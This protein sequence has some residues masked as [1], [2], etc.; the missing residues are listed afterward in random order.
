MPLFTSATLPEVA[1]KL[2]VLD[3]FGA[4]RSRLPPAPCASWIR[5]YCPG[6]IEL[7]PPK[8]VSCQLLLL[9]SRYCTVQPLKLTVLFPLLCNSMKSFLYWAP[10]VPPPPYTWLMATEVEAARELWHVK[11]PPSTRPA[12]MK[13]ASRIMQRIYPGLAAL[14][15]NRAQGFSLS[16]GCWNSR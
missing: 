8:N 11:K 6:P 4:G 12:V 5:K 3:A 9:M 1:L 2:I 13:I 16:W 7:K 15:R 10:T 14:K